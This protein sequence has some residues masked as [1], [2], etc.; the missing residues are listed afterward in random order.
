MK[1]TLDIGQLNPNKLFGQKR[2]FL[3]EKITVHENKVLKLYSWKNLV[4]V[5]YKRFSHTHHNNLDTLLIK[6]F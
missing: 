2:I 5:T 1:A 6:M 3:E 4:G